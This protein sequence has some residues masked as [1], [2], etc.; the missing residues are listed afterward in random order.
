MITSTG[1]KCIILVKAASINPVDMKVR[2]GSKGQTA[3]N[4][5]LGYDG[6]GIVRR[7]YF[8]LC[9]ILLRSLKWVVKLRILRS[10]TK[11]FLQE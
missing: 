3:S 10:A 1:L 11:F 6:A 2:S 5:I 4:R 9:L 8:R 7:Y